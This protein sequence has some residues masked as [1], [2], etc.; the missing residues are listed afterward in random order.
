MM[1]LEC[2]CPQQSSEL[3]WE[4]SKLHTPLRE[5]HMSVVHA[6]LQSYSSMQ[7]QTKRPGSLQKLSGKLQKLQA[8]L[9]ELPGP[10][11]NACPLQ[12][13]KTACHLHEGAAKLRCCCTKSDSYSAPM[14]SDEHSSTA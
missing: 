5:L 11:Q 13:P 1:R 8:P 12:S 6:P 7:P 14:L 3:A 4:G 9:Q 10:V 2:T